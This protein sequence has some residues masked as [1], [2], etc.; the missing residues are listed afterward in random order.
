MY[1]YF[2]DKNPSSVAKLNKFM[3]S[4]S[5][6]PKKKVESKEKSFNG[7]LCPKVRKPGPTG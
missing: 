7:K 2:F 6:F 3:N 1:A 4:F 5:P